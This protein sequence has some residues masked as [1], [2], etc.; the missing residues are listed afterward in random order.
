MGA[1]GAGAADGIPVCALAQ[2]QHSP[3]SAPDGTGGAYVAWLDQRLGYNTD[4]YLQ[5]VTS[6]LQRATGWPDNGVA[7]TL[8]TCTKTE[9]AL[10]ADTAGA[11]AAWADN[12][13]SSG[14]GFDIYAVRF[15]PQGTRA[16]GWP[17][18]GRLVFSAASDQLHP[19][20]ATDGAG[21]AFVAWTD[22]G[23]SPRK[24]AVQH[25]LAN[26]TLDPAW[27]ADG[28]TLSSTLPD[29]G[30]A[31]LLPD[32][33]GGVFVAWQDT[34][35]GSGDVWLQRLAAD[36]TPASGWAVG[37]GALVTATGNQ[38]A[39]KLV[40][41]GAGGAFVL[42]CDRRTAVTQLFA[43]RVAADGSL[44]VGWPANGL[45][46]AAG[47]GDQARFGALADG[48]GGMQVV[49]QDARSGVA[50]VR[51]QHLGGDGAP[52][53]PW[54][55]AG[56]ALAPATSAQVAPALVADGAGGWCA[57]WLDARQL[58]VSGADVYATRFGAD[59]AI[60]PGWDAAGTPVCDAAAEQ[61]DVRLSAAGGGNVLLFWTDARSAAT[62]G[63]DIAMAS[64]GAG[65]PSATSVHALAAVHHDGQ[66]F[67]SWQV[68]PGRGWKYRVW[69]AASPI[70]GGADLAGATFLGEVGDS[71]AY[72][73]HLSQSSN[74]PY[75]Y[76]VD[77]LAAPLDPAAGLFVVTPGTNR[78]SYYAITAQNSVFGENTT[79]VPGQ[80]ALAAAVTELLERPRP[81][82]QRDMVYN[83]HAFALYTLFT[84]HADTP[85]MSAMT[86][87]PGMAWDCAIVR[88]I[89]HWQ[90]NLL[91]PLHYRGGSLLDGIYGSGYPGEWV[92][93]LDDWLP[94]G[95]CS[96]WYGWG[97]GYDVTS[98]ATPPLTT[99]TL[100]DYT[101]R[102]VR[103]T[104]DW[105]LRTFPI[106]TTRVYAFGYSMGGAGAVLMA[107][108]LG[109]RFA[110]TMS[111]VGKSD[112]TFAS[113]PDTT[114]W[115]NPNGSMRKLADAMWGTLAANLPAA[116]G[117]HALERLNAG[118]IAEHD[119]T[120][121]IAPMW[122]FA[123]KL[124]NTM[125]WAENVP[126]WEAMQEAGRGGAFF[127]EMRHH[128]E[129]FIPT[130]AP[131][132]DPRVL[133]RYQLDQSFPAASHCTFD[134]DM[135]NGRSDD[136]APLGQLNGHLEWDPSGVDSTDHWVRSISLRPLT[137]QAGLRQPPDSTV[138]DVTIRRARRFRPLPWE[139]VTFS[140]YDIS[141]ARIAQT[142][143]ATTD[144]TGRLT[145]PGV[146]VFRTG[147][148][149][150]VQRHDITAVPP[151]GPIARPG[152]TCSRHP[153]RGV[154][155]LGVTWPGAGPGR[156]ALY[157]VGGRLVRVLW[158]G[159]AG[160][161]T[162]ALALDTGTLAPGLYLAAAEAG[163][164]RA[165]RRLVVLR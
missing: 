41:D 115:W 82:F 153:A 16:A 27:P 64:L 94:N 55:A 141:G 31:S 93:G 47:S 84:S 51:A 49:W 38:Y 58:A 116:E 90:S 36:G 120:R 52:V 126:F 20:I 104:L 87:R 129:S 79:I 5:R 135:G 128:N 4:I 159:T 122:L 11:F 65:G 138:L 46:L 40:S 7:M 125:S 109:D 78:T 154:V 149:L 13:C 146:K 9:I 143:E 17:A 30:A 163:G 131:I 133:Y 76:C 113:D 21:G 108:H 19:A 98:T 127:W 67:L 123:G 142:G 23:V 99:G 162:Q 160:P 85:L 59:G 139:P 102:R 72:D 114:C 53:A 60:A 18:N 136:G 88:P 92:L 165:T 110:A 8:V 80:N 145:L 68:P 107:T 86:N 29:S 56:I 26:G 3:V 119:S 39:P 106:D 75:G 69:R 48:S 144:P 96:Y 42:W 118:W 130:W 2:N 103:F 10:M 24:L 66:T 111:V 35:G 151:G 43:S 44:A 81:V 63:T 124:D 137:T 155:A 100:V 148:T 89:P 158:S 45:A 91:L 1:S 156:V 12:R 112:F 161:G 83:A 61:R 57:S 117:G 140:V 50:A 71:S 15:T 121:E 62:R 33:A 97:D 22:L 132:E 54:P 14:A 157:D 74:T 105:T 37:G 101:L 147:I 70:A 150:D 34:R 28:R 77:S 134:D 152:I 95:Q 6:S 32:G 164:R 25:L 73:R